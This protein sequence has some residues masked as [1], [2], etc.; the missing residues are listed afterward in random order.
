MAEKTQTVTIMLN[1]R[2][3]KAQ[4]ALRIGAIP[5]LRAG[6]RRELPV[7]EVAKHAEAFIDL[8]KSGALRA[9]DSGLT[10]MSADE[11]SAL[12]GGSSA[13]VKPEAPAPTEEKA[14]TPPPPAPPAEDPVVE[15]PSKSEEPTAEDETEPKKATAKK[16]T[17]GR[18]RK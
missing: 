5:A 13:P 18:S 3:K 16:T 14:T 12:L 7:S 2:A 4:L 1:P 11:F 17:K 9:Y 8:A 15:E 6:R 10:P